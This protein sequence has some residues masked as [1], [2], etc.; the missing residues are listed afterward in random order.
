MFQSPVSARFAEIQRG[1]R[2]QLLFRRSRGD[3]PGGDRPG[4][5]PPGSSE[6]RGSGWNDDRSRSGCDDDDRPR[7]D[8]GDADDRPPSDPP[9]GGPGDDW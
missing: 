7:S 9:P 3:R 1:T 6:D 2:E 8:R 4:D 5:A